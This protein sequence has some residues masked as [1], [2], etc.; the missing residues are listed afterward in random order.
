MARLVKI[1]VAVLALLLGGIHLRLVQQ[2]R[3]ARG[4]TQIST[5]RQLRSVTLDVFARDGSLDH[6][7]TLSF[8]LG[9]AELTV[10]ELAR[11]VRITGGP[12]AIDVMNQ[13]VPIT[14]AGNR[15]S[16]PPP[17]AALGAARQLTLAFTTAMPKPTYGWSYRAV[18]VPWA[19]TLTRG[20]VT[21][22]VVAHV[23]GATSAPGFRC[24]ADESG[25]VCAV[26]PRRR[27]TLAIPLE[28]VDDNRGKLLLGLISAAA[29]TAV[30][31]AIAR[32]WSSHAD[33]MGMTGEGAT[34]EEFIDEVRREQRARRDVKP[35]GADDLDPLEAVALIARGVT[36][37][38]GL[39]ASV[40][41]VAQFEGGFF[42]MPAPLA[43]SIWCVVAAIIA[44][45][46]VG[47]R[48]S[49]PWAAFALLC[50]CMMIALTPSA[51]FILPGIPPLFAVAAMQLTA[52]QR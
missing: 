39:L 10:V 5:E 23:N 17:P 22:Q 6:A 4:V 30:M 43:L 44:V 8:E 41:L 13:P 25:H 33:E 27:R 15:I 51:R 36:A 24:S 9:L 38:L 11:D 19:A 50:F 49:R 35:E 34:M 37:V 16:F 18:A 46:A 26:E 48:R 21:T 32:R 28:R 40:F 20:R 29:I 52:K 47:F 14:V 12:I 2:E 1:L 42:P 31:F 3:S 45:T 7:L